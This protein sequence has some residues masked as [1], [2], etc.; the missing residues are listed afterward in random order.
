MKDNNL[1]TIR[2]EIDAIDEEIAKLLNRRFNLVEDVATL[3][4]ESDI[5]VEDKAREAAIVQKLKYA[6]S[7]PYLA[8][9]IEDFY[10]KVFAVSRTFQELKRSKSKIQFS[11]IGIIGFGAIGG[12]IAK[13]LKSQDVSI[14]IGTI[15]R[16]SRDERLAIEVGDIDNVYSNIED[17][18]KSSDLII[19]ATPIA[20]IIEYAKKIASSAG[21]KKLT[22]ID[23]GSTKADIAREFENLTTSTVQF[24]P[25]HPM[26]GSGTYTGFTHSSATFFIHKPWVITPHSKNSDVEVEKIKRLILA[27][28]SIPV[29]MDPVKHDMNAARISH[30]AIVLAALLFAYIHDEHK[31]A[32]AIATSGFERITEKVSGNTKMHSQIVKEN[33]ANIRR[34]ID[35]FVAFIQK[36]QVSKST[37]QSFFEHYKSLRDQVFTK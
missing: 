20:N 22:V 3:K 28:G 7:N 34:A 10:S 9:V 6:V 36:K 33:E 23:V 31:D 26:A 19:I 11:K 4:N 13:T 35:E 32:L 1:D 27:L 2:R 5:P 29:V 30:L 21:N 18:C 24:I 12:S 37:A 14:S 8:E 17:L 25:T 15:K 16:E